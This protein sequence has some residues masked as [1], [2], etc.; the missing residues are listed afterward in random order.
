MNC[1][2]FKGG[3]DLNDRA[4]LVNFYNSLTS[5]GG[6]VWNLVNDLCG[7][8]GVSCDSSNPKR[9]YRL[10]SFFF[11]SLKMIKNFGINLKN[12]RSLSS[13]G[14]SGTIP[15]EFGDLSNLQYL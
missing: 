8:T 12:N 5:N 9:I 13:Q 14:L 3:L 4:I 15:T 10:Y 11:I 6:F 7:Q 2:S 1:N